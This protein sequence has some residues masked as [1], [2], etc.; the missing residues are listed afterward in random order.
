MK[1]QVPGGGSRPLHAPTKVAKCR[2]R[3]HVAF[4][5]GDRVVLLDTPH[6]RK[7]GQVGAAGDVV[8][9]SYEHE[10]HGRHVAYGVML[11]GVDRAYHVLPD[12]LR[13]EGG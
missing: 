7:V 6:N 4:T 11:D 1:S 12:G 2:Y 3:R 13:P 9:I 8:G 5:F 10:D